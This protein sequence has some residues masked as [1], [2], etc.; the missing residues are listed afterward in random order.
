MYDEASTAPDLPLHQQRRLSEHLAAIHLTW[1]Q[2]VEYI[3]QQIKAKKNKCLYNGM[4]LYSSSV[5]QA[6][7]IN[8]STKRTFQ[9]MG[10]MAAPIDAGSERTIRVINR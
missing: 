2:N 3:H 7:Q 5:P 8:G 9:T 10:V 1:W 4:I 6:C